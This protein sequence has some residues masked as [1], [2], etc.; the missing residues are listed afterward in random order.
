MN[1]GNCAEVA[2]EGG[3]CVE[4]ASGEAVVLVRDTQDRGGVVLTFGAEA[5][6][7]FLGRLA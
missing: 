1:Q 3:A 4:A 5:W 2:C 6:R 7:E